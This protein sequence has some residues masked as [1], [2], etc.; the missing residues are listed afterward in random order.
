MCGRFTLHTNPADLLAAFGG[1]TFPDNL[2]PRYNIAP[3]L[4]ILHVT[5]EGEKTVSLAKWGLVPFWAKD[6]KIGNRMINARAESLA[7]KPSFRDAYQH[8]RCLIIADGFFEWKKEADGKSKI[9]MYITMKSGNPFAFAGLWE[10]WKQ[11]DGDLLRTCTIITT[12]PNDLMASIHHRMPVILPDNTYDL[13]LDPGTI[14][15]EVLNGLLKPYPAE[16]MTAH[17]V[18]LTVN[19]PRHDE[20]DCIEPVVLPPQ[21]PPTQLSFL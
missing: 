3:S 10:T 17:P 15:P 18:N 11:P 14:E 13:W 5:N 8:R 19:S 7:T 1:F 6:A 16:E 4:N 21:T 9:P 2:E 12:E 20:K